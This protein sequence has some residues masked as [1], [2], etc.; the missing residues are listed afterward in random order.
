VGGA[1]GDK[2]H[3]Q[4]RCTK[5]NFIKGGVP[6]SVHAPYKLGNS[7]SVECDRGDEIGKAEGN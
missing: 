5:G 4:K 1:G 2:V 7:G 3:K 6:E